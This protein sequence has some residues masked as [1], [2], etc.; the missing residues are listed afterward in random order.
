MSHRLPPD[1]WQVV[2][3]KLSENNNYLDLLC[4]CAYVSKSWHLIINQFLSSLD[5]INIIYP[6]G[7]GAGRGDGPHG[8]AL[9]PEYI[10]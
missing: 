2:F 8:L 10:L 9:L 1:I 5:I 4:I 6:Y 7:V 3:N